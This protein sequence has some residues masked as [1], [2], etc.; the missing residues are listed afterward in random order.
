M[1]RLSYSAVRNIINV[2]YWLF[3]KREIDSLHMVI[4]PQS[5]AY[6]GSSG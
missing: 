2:D 3:T 5:K 4:L 1:L 6:T